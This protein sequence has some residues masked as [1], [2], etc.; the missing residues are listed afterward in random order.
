MALNTKFD[1][2]IFDL[3]FTIWNCGGTWCDH[4]RPPFHMSKG[5]LFDADGRK[6]ELYPDV[7]KILK[8]LKA[9]N[10]VTGI[11]SR[12]YQP[13]WAGIFLD[14]LD[15]RQYFDFEE[16]YPGEKTMHFNKLKRKSG[17]SFEK[18]IFFDD[19][20]RNIRDVSALGVTSIYVQHGI[21]RELVEQHLN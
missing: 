13:D 7:L 6:I 9:N 10:T 2:V 14:K 1:L 5:N 16:I 4:T 11:A 21:H 17:I 18:M 12:T 20:M 8:A 3:D 19:E 15:I